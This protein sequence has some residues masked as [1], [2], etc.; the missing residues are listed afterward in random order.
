MAIEYAQLRA[1]A[2]HQSAR[3]LA[4]VGQTD[5]ALKK[6]FEALQLDFTRAVTHYNIGLIYKYRRQWTES[7]RFNKRAVELAPDD[8]A[9][10]WN[11][12]I[13]A[14]ALCDWKTARAVW[15]RLG[16]PIEGGD[17]PI[18]ADFGWT[19]VRLNP[20]RDGELVWS[21]RIDPV[22]AQ[23]LSIPF[24]DSG[25]RFG[26]VV[27]HDGAPVGARMLE[28]AERPV[29]NVLELNFASGY[30]TYEVDLEVS[31]QKDLAAF[32]EICHELGVEMEDWTTSVR[33]MYKQSSEGHL[34]D[35]HS[36]VPAAQWENRHRLGLACP[37]EIRARRALARW[38]N[39]VRSVVQFSL[40]LSAPSPVRTW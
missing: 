14:T 6:Y 5:L 9:A 13:A 2:L 28:G 33:A 37:D 1:E 35:A 19:P 27:L 24:P 31:T 38:E 36:H 15:H 23:L 39:P 40:A 7:F 22:R 3:A 4:A 18:F 25:F 10:N 16:L 20:E 12:G 34:H 8:E 26:D 29:F 32:E 21:R 30:N 17:Q 11:L